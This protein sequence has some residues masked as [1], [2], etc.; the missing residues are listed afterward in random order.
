VSR[1][2]VTVTAG[3]ADK[4]IA[5]LS[6]VKTELGITGSSKDTKLN[7]LIRACGVAFAGELGRPLWRQV[8]S[9]QLPGDGGVYLPLSRWPI[10]SVS[11]VV[12]GGVTVTASEYSIAAPERS[13]LYRSNGW[14]KTTLAKER[15]YPGSGDRE[16]EYTV[17]YTGGWVTPGNLSDWTASTAYTVGE[18]VRSTDVSV[19]VLFE[20]TTAGTSDSSEPT[21][22]VDAGDTTVDNTVTWTA[23]AAVELPEDIQE[24]ALVQVADWFRGGLAIPSGI[25]SEQ[26]G[27]HSLE[28]FESGASP[29]AAVV[30][31]VLRRYK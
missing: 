28:Y 11:S 16:L 30:S 9:E 10:E 3:P 13:T 6:T 15:G 26:H 1:P 8:Y 12:I 21:W 23:R 4:S 29:M 31:S 25:K 2:V 24:V 20:C 19:L 7:R 18:F 17:A 22:D 27:P 5:V 14:A